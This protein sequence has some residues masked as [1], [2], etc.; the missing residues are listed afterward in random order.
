[1]SDDK[2]SRQVRYQRKHKEMGLCINCD[3]K[4]VVKRGKQQVFC[5]SC[6]KKHNKYSLERY[7]QRK[8]DKQ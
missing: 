5:E 7:Y 1:M 3:N 2:V 4:A 8:G 6:R